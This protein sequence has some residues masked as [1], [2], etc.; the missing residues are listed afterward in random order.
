MTVQSIVGD[1]ERS[2]VQALFPSSSKSIQKDSASAEVD[3]LSIAPVI[4]WISVMLF[5]NAF[6][7]T[8]Q[9]L[10]EFSYIC[11]AKM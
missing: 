4:N 9:E 7:R 2:Q 10:C 1:G 5:N 11:S 8:M 3:P 6:S